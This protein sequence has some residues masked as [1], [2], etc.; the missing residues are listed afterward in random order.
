MQ[1]EQ[2]EILWL[3]SV[4]SSYFSAEIQGPLRLTGG[5]RMLMPPAP[6]ASPRFWGQQGEAVAQRLTS[7]KVCYVHT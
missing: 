7:E 3:L 1:G 6:I 5:E 4:E 2:P